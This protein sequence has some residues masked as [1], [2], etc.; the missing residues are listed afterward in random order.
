MKTF[1]VISLMIILFSCGPRYQY[2]ITSS[3][4]QEYY[5]NFYNITGDSCVL[6]HKNQGL[7][8]TPGEPYKL[9]G[10]YKIENLNNKK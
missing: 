10:K 3:N 9:C 7:N 4:G 2:R 5:C 1:T 8:N 6:F